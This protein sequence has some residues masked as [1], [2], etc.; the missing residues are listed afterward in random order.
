MK[1]SFLIALVTVLSVSGAFAQD[2]TPLPKQVNPAAKHPID[3]VN[4]KTK[5]KPV[6]QKAGENTKP[7]DPRP[8]APKK[9]V[10]EQK[11]PTT[12][13]ANE[14]KTSKKHVVNEAAKPNGPQKHHVVAPPAPMVPKK[15]GIK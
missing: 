10:T 5:L 12:A 11:N 1:K 8:A 13:T 7:V 3:P 2:H 9:E 14:A 4:P 15:G 6:D